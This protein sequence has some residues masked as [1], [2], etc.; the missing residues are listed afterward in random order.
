MEKRILIV[1]VNWIGDVLFS[2][3][4]IKAVREANPDGY[5]ACLLHPRCKE[6]LEANPRLD[7][8]IIYDEEGEHKSLFGKIKLIARL[9][10]KKFDTAFILH[11][12]F[13]KALIATLA[14]IK[15]RVG[16]PTKHRSAL[17]TKA[18]EEPAGEIHKVEYFLNI[19]RAAGIETHETSYE[20]FIKDPDRAFAK[21]FF[22]K[23]GVTGEDIVVAICPG[24]NWGPKRWPKESFASLA[25]SLIQKFNA[26]IIVTGAQK[27]AILAEEIEKLMKKKPINISGATTLKELGAIF[28]RADLVVAND[29]GSM[30]LAVAMKTPVIALFGPTSPGLTGPYGRGNYKVI[31]RNAECAIPCY[32]YTCKDNSC[33]KKISVGEVL[34]EASDMLARSSKL[35]AGSKNDN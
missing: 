8:I 33:M 9:R 30:H 11:K 24:G 15:E 7:E 32:D 16:Y 5:I 17:L 27:D 18:I 6:M 20:F 35:E 29:T 13:T 21:D 2:T 28:E 22:A 31:S 10:G 26:R 25:D 19:A 3:P 1:N 34:K 23:H 12:S 4:F 14:G